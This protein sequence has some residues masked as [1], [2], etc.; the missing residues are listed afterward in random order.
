MNF[1]RWWCEPVIPQPPPRSEMVE[2]VFKRGSTVWAPSYTDAL[3][4]L[5]RTDAT[6]FWANEISPGNWEVQFDGSDEPNVIITVQGENGV[7]AARAARWML[8]LDLKEKQLVEV[9][10]PQESPLKRC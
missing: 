10:D 6:Y 7:E 3:D 5:G 9:K 2:W 4:L 1:I 8:G